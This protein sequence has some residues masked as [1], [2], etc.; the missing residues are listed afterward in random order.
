MVNINT[1]SSNNSDVKTMDQYTGI[2]L[3][4]GLFFNSA[5][6]MVG[7]IG[8]LILPK[9]I[10]LPNSLDKNKQI[11][12]MI[13][14]YFLG[15]ISLIIIGLIEIFTYKNYSNYYKYKNKNTKEKWD[16]AIKYYS[17]I[18]FAIGFLL[19]VCMIIFFIYYRKN[20]SNV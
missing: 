19:L 11:K 4:V 16:E 3:G 8:M 2:G 12:S 6:I 1:T 13:L 5:L 10:Y 14:L 15:G 7:I 18:N 9:K 17:Y 20:K